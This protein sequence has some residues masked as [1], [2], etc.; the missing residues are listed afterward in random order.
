MPN[1]ACISIEGAVNIRTGHRQIAVELLA[2]GVGFGQTVVLGHEG[3]DLLLVGQSD[4]I[5]AEQ[6]PNF[7]E[8]INN[9][10]QMSGGVGPT[11]I[12]GIAALLSCQTVD[13]DG[14][15]GVK[16][17]FMALQIGGIQCGDIRL[18]Y[19]DQILGLTEG[20][21][22]ANRALGEGSVIPNDGGSTGTGACVAGGDDIAI[23]VT[24]GLQQTALALT[25]FTDGGDTDVI[26]L[27]SLNALVQLFG[28]LVD[29]GQHRGGINFVHDITVLIAQLLILNVVCLGVEIITA[30]LQHYPNGCQRLFPAFH[31][32]SLIL[33]GCEDHINL[34]AD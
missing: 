1:L 20:D 34:L 11:G 30:L 15:D 2:V 3:L 6:I 23:Q 17:Q 14:A 16:V 18:N 13:I 27:E 24:D 32:L 7:G 31:F 12:V 26:T 19:L 22:T 33:S 8:I 5:G 21:P 9:L 25:L 28:C 10:F 4:G 29:A